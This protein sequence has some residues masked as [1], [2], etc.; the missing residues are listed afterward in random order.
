MML[1]RD[2]SGNDVV[3]HEFEFPAVP[4]AELAITASIEGHD[5]IEF[6]DDDNYL[7]TVTPGCKITVDAAAGIQFM[8]MP[9]EPVLM[10]SLGI[11]CRCE[12]GLMRGRFLHPF[13]AHNAAAIP[14]T[15]IK[16]DL[17]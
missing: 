4:L 1:W 7:A 15:V 9:A 6:G 16:V 3:R 11:E 17:A 10:F 2:R 5:Q 8:N 12:A 14:N 13:F